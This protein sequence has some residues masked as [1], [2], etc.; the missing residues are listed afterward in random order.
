MPV[1]C[2]AAKAAGKDSREQKKA[3]AKAF[4]FTIL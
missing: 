2:V 4:V 1:S 3:I